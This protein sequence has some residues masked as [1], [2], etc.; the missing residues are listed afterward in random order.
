M[1]VRLCHMTHWD[2]FGIICIM[3]DST[4][5]RFFACRGRWNTLKVTW[6]QAHFTCKVMMHTRT[7]FHWGINQVPLYHLL[8]IACIIF[9]EE[10]L[11]RLREKVFQ[12]KTAHANADDASV[13]QL[14]I[15][16]KYKKTVILMS[17]SVW[18]ECAS[19]AA[20]CLHLHS[21]VSV[22][23]FCDLSRAAVI[24]RSVKAASV[25]PRQWTHS[26]MS[27]I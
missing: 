20:R 3:Q 21:V 2:R 5:L 6:T 17:W 10:V 12:N 19:F 18:V 13:S 26:K 1:H 8:C 15:N 25:T 23:K 24:S 27:Y 7:Y 11:G 16:Y 22:L 9:Y 4:A 14:L